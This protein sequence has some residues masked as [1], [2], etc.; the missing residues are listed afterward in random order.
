M[1]PKLASV[2]TGLLL[3]ANLV[4]GRHVPS[5]ERDVE[6]YFEEG[7]DY[8]HAIRRELLAPKEAVGPKHFDINPDELYSLPADPETV[9]A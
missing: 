8:L 1:H 4:V 3:A 6:T 2:L 9:S 5:Y 7:D